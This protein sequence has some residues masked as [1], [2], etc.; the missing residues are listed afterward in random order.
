MTIFDVRGHGRQKGHTET[1]RG[2]EYSVDL[3]PKIKIEL[4]LPDNLVNQVIDAIVKTASTGKIGDGKS[5]FRK[6]TKLS[7]FEI[8]S[9]GWRHSNAP[10]LWA[11]GGSC[12]CWLTARYRRMHIRPSRKRYGSNSSGHTTDRTQS[13]NARI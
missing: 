5:S 13:T 6:S 10:P 4:V 7:G 11:T 12:L 8:R 3:L 1:Y 9:E 2:R